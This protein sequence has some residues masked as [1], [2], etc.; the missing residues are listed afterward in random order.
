MLSVPESTYTSNPLSLLP[1]LQNYVSR[2]PLNQFEQSDWA[3]LHMDLT[4]YLADALIHLHGVRWVVAE[5]PSSP[6]GYRYVIETANSEASAKRVDPAD[7]VMVEFRNLPIE[8]VRMMASAELSL[9]LSSSAGE[10]E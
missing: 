5:D 7:V 10:G 1:A 6:R 9:G 3:A 2:L 8:V 4:S